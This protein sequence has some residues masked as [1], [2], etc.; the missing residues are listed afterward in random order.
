MDE[1][2][3]QESGMTGGMYELGGTAFRSVSRGHSP[4]TNIG[5]YE[6]HRTV[7]SLASALFC[8]KK[9]RV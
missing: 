7:G 4:S 8:R 3:L 2:L 6:L 1:A 5:S 9:L